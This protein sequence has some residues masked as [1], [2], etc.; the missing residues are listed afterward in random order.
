MYIIR[1]DRALNSMAC[2]Y[3]KEFIVCVFTV[4]VVISLQDLLHG[5]EFNYGSALADF[6]KN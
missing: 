1:G 5:M 4:R 6:V 3:I 2:Y